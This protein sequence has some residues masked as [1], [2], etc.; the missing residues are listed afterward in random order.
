[1]HLPAL[2]YWVTPSTLWGVLAF[3][4]GTAIAI[5]AIKDMA[6]RPILIL[7]WAALFFL[8]S[9]GLYTAAQ[10]AEEADVQ[11]NHQKEF[12]N[13]IADVLKVPQGKSAQELAD[14]LSKRLTELTEPI[15]KDVERLKNPPRDNMTLYV[16]TAVVAQVRNIVVDKDNPQKIT[17]QRVSSS[18]PLN[19]NLA[20]YFQWAEI[21]CT[22]MAPFGSATMG[23]IKIIEYANIS[24]IA[25]GRAP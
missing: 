3:A 18:R 20:F 16:G 11:I 15:K 17:F 6:R 4:A 21:K 2:H 9:L 10:Q 1:M 7:C 14:M 12:E 25:I 22:P 5:Y 13:R 8:T 19:F 24:C 23:A